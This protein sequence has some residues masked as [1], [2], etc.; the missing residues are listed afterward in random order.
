MTTPAHARTTL[1][2][3]LEMTAR[4]VLPPPPQPRLRTMMLKA[5]RP[6]VHFYRYLYDRIGHDY[7]WVDRLK[8]SDAEIAGIVHDEKVA[9]YVLH[10]EGWPAGMAELD[11]REPDVCQLAYFGLMPEAIGQ[12]LGPLFLHHAIE[13]AWVEPIEKLLVNTCTLD[14]PKALALYQ[15]FGFVPYA[16]EERVIEVPAGFSR[17]S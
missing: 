2:T 12:R 14:H 6:P 15:R 13:N 4:P 11:F 17:Q 5:E 9:I 10:A 8:L 16:R 3:Y 7:F 1:V